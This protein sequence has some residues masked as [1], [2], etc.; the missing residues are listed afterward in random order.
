[1][2]IVWAVAAAAL[3]AVPLPK[4]GA[5]EGKN[6]LIH[7]KT[8]LSLDDAQLCVAYNQIWAAAESG[9]KVQVLVDASAVATYRKGW[10]GKNKLEKYKI[11]ENLR[12]ILASEFGLPLE[13]VPATYGEYLRML[14]SRG[15]E[16]Y[17]NSEMLVTYG[18]EKEY[19]KAENLAVDF[20]RP[21]GIKRLL[22]L[23]SGAD[24]YL[25]Y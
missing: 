3:L 21:V 6:V 10:M 5:E 15:V 1:M 23:V 22:E 25:V 19:G 17:V 2:K 8:G 7:L 20:F 9:N 24:V 14:H 12:N 11:P 16:F 18:I 4:A 13:K